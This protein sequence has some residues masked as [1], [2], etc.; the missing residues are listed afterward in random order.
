[1]ARLV[2]RSGGFWISD[3]GFW[4][5]DYQEFVGF[6]KF[7]S[8]FFKLVRGFNGLARIFGI[9]VI[10]LGCFLLIRTVNFL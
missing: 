9:I 1:M 3:F 7:C 4:I 2:E 10:F 8:C 5:R 6:A